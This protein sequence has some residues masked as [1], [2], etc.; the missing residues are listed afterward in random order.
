MCKNMI[1]TL[2]SKNFNIKKNYFSN[3]RLTNLL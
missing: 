3:G 2:Y 1:K